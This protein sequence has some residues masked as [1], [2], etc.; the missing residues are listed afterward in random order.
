MDLT[1]LTHSA[2]NAAI[3][4]GAEILAVYHTADMEVEYKKDDSPLTL[5]D[6]AAHTAIVPHLESTGYPILSEEGRN[7]AYEERRHW[8][9]F[10]LVDPLDGTKEFIKR[11]GEFTVNI[12]L[13]REGKPVIGVIY[14]PVTGWLYW[15]NLEEGAWKEKEK[16]P[17][18]KLDRPNTDEVTSIVGSRSHMDEATA[19]FIAKFPG[20]KSIS[21]GSSLKFMAVAENQ[22]QIYP[23]FFPCMEWDTGA[24]HAIVSALG[25]TVFEPSTGRELR[26]N[27]K[28]LTS[29]YFICTLSPS[30]L[31]ET[32]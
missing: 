6:K 8:E 15:A 25:G 2:K 4:A 13:V 5:A 11:N 3:A 14:V 17:P 29:P 1:G 23:R 7:I 32:L 16:S 12:A 18:V 21:M 27:K 20:A 19:A 31:P 24:A 22:A 28:D 10:W 30:L 9:T 26:Y